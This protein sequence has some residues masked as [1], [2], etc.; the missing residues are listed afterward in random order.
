MLPTSPLSRWCSFHRW[1][2]RRLSCGIPS[3]HRLPRPGRKAASVSSIFWTTPMLSER[4]LIY[5][6][7][8]VSI[9][10]NN[11]G[12]QIRLDVP[13]GGGPQ[14]TLCVD[15]Y[16][17]EGAGPH[18]ALLCLHGGAW[19]RGTQRLYQSWGPWL[20]ERG[21]AAVAVDYRLSTDVSPGWPGVWDDVCRSLDWLRANASSLAIDP[22][23]IAAMGDS[24]GAHMSAMLSLDE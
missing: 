5:P 23:R 14:K 13:Y 12:V 20:A 1:P 6:K 15:V 4:F 9:C 11:S 16:V 7:R 18:P 3:T 24:A 19:L 22:A 8:R 2:T 17:P 21:Y 10:L